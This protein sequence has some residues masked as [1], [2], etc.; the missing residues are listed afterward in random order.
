VF[1]VS[2]L[3]RWIDQYTRRSLAGVVYAV[4]VIGEQ[5]TLGMI[6]GFDTGRTEFGWIGNGG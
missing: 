2:D 3:D 1:L 6:T 4:E 5:E